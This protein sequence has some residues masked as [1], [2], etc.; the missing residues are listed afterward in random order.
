MRTDDA[1]ER[2]IDAIIRTV[3]AMMLHSEILF[4]IIFREERD[5]QTRSEAYAARF[6]EASA[7]ALSLIRIPVI[8]RLLRIDENAK[9][10]EWFETVVECLSIKSVSSAF[11]EFSE[12]KKR[13]G[14]RFDIGREAAFELGYRLFDGNQHDALR[15]DALMMPL[16]RFVDEAECVI[17]GPRIMDRLTDVEL[18]PR[19]TFDRIAEL[20]K[21]SAHE[22]IEAV[23]ALRDAE[24]DI[25]QRGKP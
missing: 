9:Q 8:E 11:D 25:V 15:A 7:I 6:P 23:V 12:I 5:A 22:R 3:L 18:D 14:R 1:E 2:A 13:R 4:R 17:V 10:D 19:E 20:A 24:L 16:S 21:L